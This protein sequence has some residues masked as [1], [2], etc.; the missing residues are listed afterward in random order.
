[1]A[2]GRMALPQTDVTLPAKLPLV[3]TRQFES[4][5]RAGRWFGATWT[6]TADQRLEVDAETVRW[7]QQQ[8]QTAIEAFRT[9]REA[10]RQAADAHNAKVEAFNQ[11]AERYNAAALAG[12]N[13]GL[14]PTEPGTFTDPSVAARREA[15]EI[16][17]EA[18]R[19]R[20]SAMAQ[21]PRRAIQIGLSQEAATTN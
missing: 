12:R 15:V 13:P 7:A 18:R 20:T 3:F 5:Y 4:S 19:Q 16:L 8:A 11:A 17:E 6:S 1:M 10:Y 2:T 21:L 9:A 14:R